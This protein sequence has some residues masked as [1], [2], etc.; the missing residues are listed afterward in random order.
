MEP[1]MLLL[2]CWLAA[3]AAPA[4]GLQGPRVLAM[5]TSSS[6]TCSGGGASAGAS[7]GVPQAV[8]ALLSAFGALPLLQAAG[9]LLL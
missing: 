1:D 5:G 4:Q 2:Q 7:G 6:S 3:A 8:A 9:R